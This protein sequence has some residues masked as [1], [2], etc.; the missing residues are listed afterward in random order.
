MVARLTWRCGADWRCVCA[1]APEPLADPGGRVAGALLANADRLLTHALGVLELGDVGLA[2][3]LAIL[4]MEDSAKAI[5]IH[6]RRVVI[7]T[8]LRVSR[9]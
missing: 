4:G 6:E 9:S 1:E 3:S 7:A 8:R 2:R 5:A